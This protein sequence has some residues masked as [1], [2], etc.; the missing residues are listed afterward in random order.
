MIDKLTQEQEAL[1]PVYQEKWNKIALSTESIDF[2]KVKADI[3]K[4]CS[5]LGINIPK[6]SFYESPYTAFK[7]DIVYPCSE[8][9]SQLRSKILINPTDEISYSSKNYLINN[10]YFN[11]NVWKKLEYMLMFIYEALQNDLDDGDLFI[12]ENACGYDDYCGVTYYYPEI[13]SLNCIYLDFCISVLDIPYN[14]EIWQVYQDI[15][16]N[17]GWIFKDYQK[18]YIV[19]N[20]PVKITFDNED[21]TIHAQGKAAIQYADGYAI[22]SYYGVPLPEKYGRIHP[23]NWQSK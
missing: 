16:T 9:L 3:E 17:C 12:N 6:I 7:E 23:S 20:R 21:L 8:F 10:L 14:K 18:N 4:A 15:I 1:I 2:N 5:I 22:Y 11:Q 19:C 13:L